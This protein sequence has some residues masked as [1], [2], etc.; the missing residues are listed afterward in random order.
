MMLN[1]GCGLD[2]KGNGCVNVDC[3]P[4]EAIQAWARHDLLPM[5]K[6]S[7]DTPFLQFDLTQGWPWG[8]ETV[9]EI[10]ADNVLEHFNDEALEHFLKEAFR[11]MKPGGIMYGK[12]PD[13]A[14]VAL[15]A[16]AHNDVGGPMSHPPGRYPL[17]SWNALRNVGYG[18][19]HRQL[20]TDEMLE[21]WLESVGFLAM[22]DN[23]DRH[24][25]MYHATKPFPEA[26]VQQRC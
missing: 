4:L 16:T 7:A 22:A 11:V 13:V 20:F 23:H 8:D 26:E 10:I 15:E 18:S 25:V 2:F 24:M 1:L 6:H 14:A 19:E 12:V 5:P 17:A 21:W 9:D 3:C